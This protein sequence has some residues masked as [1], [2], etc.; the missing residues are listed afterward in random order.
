MKCLKRG[1]FEIMKCHKVMDSRKK[2]RKVNAQW[3][4]NE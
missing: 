4:E 3:Q 1:L 2:K